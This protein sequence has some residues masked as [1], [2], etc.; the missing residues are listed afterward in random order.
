MLTLFIFVADDV[1]VAGA[2]FV[3]GVYAVV[4]SRDD[5]CYNISVS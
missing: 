2:V 4:C 3:A 1:F 5:Q